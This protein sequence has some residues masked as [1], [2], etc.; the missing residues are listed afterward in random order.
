MCESCCACA[1][2]QKLACRW[3]RLQISAMQNFA[4]LKSQ[5]ENFYE[6]IGNTVMPVVECFG[7]QV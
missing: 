5:A 1:A 6:A 4:L 7:G 2:P 3:Q